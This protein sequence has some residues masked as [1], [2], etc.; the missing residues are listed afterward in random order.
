MRIQGPKCAGNRPQG[1]WTGGFTLV[2]LLVVVTAISLLL[3]LVL[4]VATAVRNDAV[5]TNEMSAARSLATAW[6]GY[7]M[8][9][10]GRV[11]P[12]YAGGFRARDAAGEWV[13]TQTTPI[14][15]NRWPLRLAP[16]LGHDF[17]SMYSGPVARELDQLAAT[18]TEEILYAVS[19]HPA[20]GLN[21]VFVG[22]D[23]NYGGFSEVFRQTF[24][25]YYVTRLSSIKRPDR[26]VV[27]AT[28]H[29]EDGGPSGGGGLV[30]GFFRVLP[31][32]WLTPLWAD[33]H[34]PEDPAS[35][36]FLSDR[37]RRTGGERVCIVT[38]ADGGVATETIESLRDMQRWS[39]VARHRDDVIEAQGP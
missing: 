2:E 14:A 28:A 38:T 25:D 10:R 30:E 18:P 5:R 29:G 36:G 7:S 31:P 12:G 4:H 34:D 6:N 39:N 15:A 11:L 3:A 35:S 21:S 17:A 16:Y 22:G 9:H 13:D 24:G 37:H 1:A 8:D 26:L 32:S 27:F 19:V 23:E 20:F 33:E